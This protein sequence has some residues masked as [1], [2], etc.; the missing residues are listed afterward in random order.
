RLAANPRRA[1][2][3]DERLGAAWIRG[4]ATRNHRL[5][6]AMR[7]LDAVSPLAVLGRG[8]AV[9]TDSSGSILRRAA[10]AAPGDTVDVRLADG[11]LEA[12]I[13]R[14]GRDRLS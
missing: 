10:D 2:A 5:A 12:R 14:S 13:V 7:G 6:L 3:L 11:H 9:V 4:Q 8:Y 1:Q